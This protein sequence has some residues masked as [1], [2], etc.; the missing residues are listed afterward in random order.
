MGKPG[1]EFEIKGKQKLDLLGQ[2]NTKKYQGISVLENKMYNAPVFYHQS[3]RQDFFCCLV[4]GTNESDDKKI[5][6]RELDSVY[7]VGQIEPKL[8][9]Y[10]PTSRYFQTF[11]K[12][13]AKAYII[14]LLQDN[15][16]VKFAKILQFFPQIREQILKNSLKESEIDIDRNGECKKTDKFDIESFKEKMTPEMIC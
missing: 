1:P 11:L 8:E 14:R 10:N 3:N 4:Q 15:E 5:I 13:R 6:I 16:T 12:Q 2:I 9:V 7:T